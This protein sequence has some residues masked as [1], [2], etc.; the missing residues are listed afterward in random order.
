MYIHIISI[1]VYIY[2]YKLKKTWCIPAS[3][4]E[5]LQVPK[6]EARGS[7]VAQQVEGRLREQRPNAGDGELHASRDLGGNNYHDGR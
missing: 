2:I 7:S 1:Y 6:A 3:L 4:A 5:Q